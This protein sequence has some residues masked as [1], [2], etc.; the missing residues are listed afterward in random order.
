MACALGLKAEVVRV[1][2][3]LPWWSG[4]ILD[5]STFPPWGYWVSGRG[6]GFCVSRVGARIV[7]AGGLTDE[8]VVCQHGQWSRRLTPAHQLTLHG[9]I[10]T[11]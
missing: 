11:C 3:V 2:A 6:L 8:D 7:R 9:S 10:M 4:Q 1:C 5:R